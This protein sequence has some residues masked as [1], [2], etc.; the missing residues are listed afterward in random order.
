MNWETPTK[1]SSW[2]TRKRE[3]VRVLWNGAHCCVKTCRCALS[4][5]QNT[6]I[7]SRTVARVN[8]QKQRRFRRSWKS[9]PTASCPRDIAKE[10]EYRGSHQRGW[11]KYQRQRWL[12]RPCGTPASRSPSS[13]SPTWCAL[14]R[15]EPQE[16]ACVKWLR[17]MLN[18][19]DVVVPLYSTYGFLFIVQV[20]EKAVHRR[21]WRTWLRDKT[22]VDV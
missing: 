2:A 3:S 20:I 11:E 14:V 10:E 12:S 8:A 6:L 19:C 15:F 5:W 9:E 17:R 21:R 1:P 18:L 22:R 13:P 16:Y 7:R 4:T